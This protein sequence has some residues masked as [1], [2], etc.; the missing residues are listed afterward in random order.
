[1]KLKWNGLVLASLMTASVL[2]A[3]D[4][5]QNAPAEVKIET[6]AAKL[7]W[8]D[9]YTD[10]YQQA[11]TEKK[12]LLIVFSNADLKGFEQT[13][14]NDEKVQ[15]LLNKVVRVKLPLDAEVPAAEGSDAKAEKLLDQP[16]FGQM[17][18]KPGFAVI[19]L[20]DDKTSYYGHVVSAHPLN[21]VYQTNTDL[22]RTVL[23]LPKATATQRAL[24]LAVLSHPEAPQSAT[25]AA[26]PFLMEQ[27][28]HHSQLMVN[29]GSV[30]HHDW[31]TRSSEVS[32]R[33]G[34][35]S[36]VAAMAFSENI[37]EAGREAIDMW[38]GSGVHWG[39]VVT[40]HQY[41]GYD[42][43]RSPGGGWYATGIF[44]N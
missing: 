24:V 36:E 12:Q 19:D 17:Y 21:T 7:D 13:A 29:Y 3:A 35:P 20:T 1:M 11:K 33:L 44:A 30:G 26:E 14:L 27:A 2:L 4:A 15:P 42:M 31:G 40:P 8:H 10:A 39:M 6:P 9:N 28:R 16:A 25:G 37:L 5:P 23:Q 22:L 43:V 38:R 34:S 32:A 41:Y 18:K